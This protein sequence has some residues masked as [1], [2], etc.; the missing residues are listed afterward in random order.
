MAWIFRVFDAFHGPRLFEFVWHITSRVSRLSQDEID[1]ASSVLG[2]N[3][4]RY[5]SVR[6][7][8]DGL[9]RII[10]K[11]NKGR[12]FT[13]FNTINL[14]G[15]GSQSRTNVGIVVHELIHVFQYKLV[16]SI[17]IYQSLRAQQTDGY[18]YGGWRQLKED[19]SN[20]KHFS[21]YNREQQGQIAQDY[22][23]DVISRGLADDD[24]VRWAYEPLIAELKDGMI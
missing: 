12:A 23:N 17:Y 1:S 11:L 9:L 19:W 2:T 5:D 20:G 15:S 6:V 10:F 8:E 7:A 22:Y 13:T 16:R 4:L 21:G 14:P 24:P 3:T 18:E